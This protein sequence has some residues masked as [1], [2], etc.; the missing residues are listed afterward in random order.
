MALPL[1]A[2]KR[3]KLATPARF[4]CRLLF[5]AQQS[6]KDAAP[7]APPRSSFWA[8]D[9]F[10]EEVVFLA[11]VVFL[12]LAVFFAEEVVFF[13]LVVVF[14]PEEVV[15]FPLVEVPNALPSRAAGQGTQHIAAI[16]LFAA[17]LPLPPRALVSRPP[18]RLVRMSLLSL[19]PDFLLLPPSRLPASEIRVLPS[20][21]SSSP[22][23]K[24]L[25]S[26]PPSPSLW[27]LVFFFWL[28]RAARSSGAAMARI[29]EVSTLLAPLLLATAFCTVSVSPPRI[30][31]RILAPS[32]VSTFCKRLAAP[33]CW[34]GRPGPGQAVGPVLGGGILRHGT[35]KPAARGQDI[36]GVLFT[37]AGLARYGG[38]H[39]AGKKISQIHLSAPLSLFLLQC[40]EIAGIGAVGL[41][42]LLNGPL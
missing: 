39:T 30:L 23:P 8:V 17:L 35:Y 5:A 18:A 7:A 1:R 14:F 21:S 22:P 11:E 38:D 34:Y 42:G 12:P 32:S 33:C 28:P 40:A 29:L 9:F 20:S 4:L 15:F 19:L 16:A 24:R 13:P 6:G 10:L 26:S 3:R 41:K 25:V 37:G 2:K 36:L 27:V 31:V